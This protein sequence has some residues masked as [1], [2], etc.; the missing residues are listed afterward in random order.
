MANTLPYEKITDALVAALEEGKIPW[1]K[2]WSGGVAPYNAFSKHVYKGINP[3]ILGL[4][5]YN[6]PRWA[7]FNQIAQHGGNLKGQH[8]TAVVAWNFPEKIDPKT[9]LK[10]VVP[11]LKYIGVFNVE[12]A[13]GLNLPALNSEKKT[14]TP[15]ESAEAIVKGYSD[16]PRIT[17]GGNSAFYAPRE[18]KIGMPQKED[19]DS[20]EHYYSTL[21][22][23]MAHS[24]GHENRLNRSEVVGSIRFGN[25]DYSKEELVAEFCACYLSNYA[26]IAN[27]D[28]DKNT[29]AYLQNWIGKL[30]ED[31]KLAVFAATRAQK[32][33]DY[34]L[35]VG[36]ESI[37][38]VVE[39]DVTD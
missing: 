15:I 37:E 25:E 26:G 30:K 1:H 36:K 19:F 18:D 20:P 32:A 11:F 13:T 17:Y 9:G 39:E 28:T 35:G 10:K 4:S 21:F 24:T 23:E 31:V 5:P 3:I 27:S 34:I 8:A 12:Q 16:R 33:S 7:T 6:D 22:H 29:K 38:S 14:H 2:P